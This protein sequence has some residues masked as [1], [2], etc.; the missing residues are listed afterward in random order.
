MTRKEQKSNFYFTIF[1]V[2]LAFIGT[3]I[4]ELIHWTY[5]YLSGWEASSTS[6]LLSG[7][8]DVIMQTPPSP[9]SLWFFYM[10]PAIII[11]ITIILITVYHPDRFARVMGIV[12][13]ALNLASYSP[14]IP[15]SDSYN[16]LQVLLTSGVHS[17]TAN[18]IHWIIYLSAIAIYII[19]IYI[20]I[21]D[22]N[23]DA[24]KRIRTLI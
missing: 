5:A 20:V 4:H 21:E 22:N 23:K 18:L 14:E 2:L 1:L 12:I 6:G 17:F 19:Y 8:T 3:R 24:V 10:A 13:I 11:Y 16:A 15:S 9:I 7:F